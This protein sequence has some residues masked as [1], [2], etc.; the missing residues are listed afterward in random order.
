MSKRQVI[1]EVDENNRVTACRVYEDENELN[2]NLGEAISY[3]LDYTNIIQLAVELE[4][5]ITREIEAQKR[6]NEFEYR[7]ALYRLT[8]EIFDQADGLTVARAFLAQPLLSF[9]SKM[10]NMK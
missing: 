9:V 1:V 2:M 6:Q 5:E 10:D 3:L 8:S 4:D 7:K